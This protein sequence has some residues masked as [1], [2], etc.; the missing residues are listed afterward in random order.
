MNQPA[1]FALLAKEFRTQIRGSRPALF[2]SV[3]IGL[4]LFALLWLYKT[5]VGQVQ[6]GAPLIGP[7]IGQALFV[8]LTLA[9]QVLLVFLA[10]A[11]T[12]NSISSEHERGTYDI[13]LATPLP[14]AGIVFTKLIVGIAFAGLLLIA[15]LP[16][17]SIV[18]L[19]GGVQPEDLGRVLLTVV[20]TAVLGCTLGL[21]CSII[22]RQTYTATLLC[23]ALLVT[24]TAGTLFAANIWSA[25]H[26]LAAAP[27]RYLV[28]NPLSAAASALAQAQPPGIV[29]V[30]VLRPA[31]LLGLL[32]RGSLNLSGGSAVVLPFFRASW[33]F[34]VG[35]TLVL[36]W[37]SLHTVEATR[38][39]R[40]WRISRTDVVLLGLLL[41]WGGVAW[42]SRA[43]WLAGLT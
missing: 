41:V 8:G 19:F 24:V 35:L 6:Q 31:A 26:G 10:P 1:L 23:Y 14:A 37:L 36:L 30:D 25:L 7:Q 33:M 13:L 21:A 20:L 16:L 42:V 32:T 18:V 4:L 12:L 11:I 2:L 5:L 9:V 29:T 43:W 3:Y 15:A 22:T 28:A 38:Y 17:Y 40:F 39:R 27:T 34:S